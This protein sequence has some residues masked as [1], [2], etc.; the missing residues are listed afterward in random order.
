MIRYALK[1][2]HGHTFDGWFASAAAFDAQL[3]A[4]QVSCAVCGGADVSKALM[5]PQVA[6]ISSVAADMPEVPKSGQPPLSKEA[7]EIAIA[8]MRKQVEENATYVG[9]KFA[10]KARAMHEGTAPE[11]SIYGEATAQEARQLIEEGVPVISLP[12][13]PKQKLQ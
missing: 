4:G 11:T 12:F 5:A 3:A 8:K 2:N 1:C 13:K 6:L 9:G 10:E 7:M